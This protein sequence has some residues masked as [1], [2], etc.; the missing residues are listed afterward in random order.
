MAS[1][2]ARFNYRKPEAGLAEW[3]VD[4]VEG[5]GPAFFLCTNPSTLYTLVL[6]A[7]HLDGV[8]DLSG[9]LL[10]RLN[11]HMTELGTDRFEP[12]P[13]TGQQ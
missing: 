11:L 9:R 5:L 1:D 2:P 8:A 3:Y 6:S 10:N 13:T 4:I 12:C 7:D